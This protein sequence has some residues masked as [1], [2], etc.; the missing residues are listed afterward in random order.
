[1]VVRQ[2]DF[3]VHDPAEGAVRIVLHIGLNAAYE[4]GTTDI[5]DIMT[6]RSMNHAISQQGEGG[7]MNITCTGVP[8]DL[9]HRNELFVFTTTEGKRNLTECTL[10]KAKT[11]HSFIY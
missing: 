8:R 5:R 4:C 6:D 2:T 7:G 9:V 11:I 1:M 3:H 10:I